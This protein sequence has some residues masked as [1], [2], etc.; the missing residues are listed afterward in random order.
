MG[1]KP[2]G[3][4]NEHDKVVRREAKN[5]VRNGWTVRAD[6]AGYEPPEPIGK[7]GVVP[8]IVAAKRGHTRIVEVETP[9]SLDSDKEQRATI[10]RSAGHKQRTTFETIVTED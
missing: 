1:N 5:L 6:L 3:S 8:D 10:A 2:K 4:Q 9:D 7:K